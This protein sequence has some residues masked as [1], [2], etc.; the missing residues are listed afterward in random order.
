MELAVPFAI[1]IVFGIGVLLAGLYAGGGSEAI[2]RQS[3]A[4]VVLALVLIVIGIVTYVAASTPGGLAILVPIVAAA[5][6]IV[7]AVQARSISATRPTSQLPRVAI[8]MWFV[9]VLM[10]TIAVS[11]ALLLLA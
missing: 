2:R 7:A 4:L 6:A 5:S 3:E 8:I 10:G 9:A 1:A 11:S